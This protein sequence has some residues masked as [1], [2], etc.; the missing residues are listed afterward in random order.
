MNKKYQTRN[1]VINLFFCFTF[2][3]PSLCFSAICTESTIV[4]ALKIKNVFHFA[5]ENCENTEIKIKNTIELR[6]QKVIDGAGKMKL[7]WTGKG[8]CS[9]KENQP[10][11]IKVTGSNNVL[12]GFSMAWSPDGI[13]LLGNNNTVERVVWDKVCEDALTNRGNGNVVRRSTFNKSQDKCI[14]TTGQLRVED[15]VFKDCARSIGSCA[16]KANSGVH[17]VNKCPAASFVTV[18]R[19]KF[20][21]CRS[22]A[23]RATGKSARKTVG[24]VKASENEFFNCTSAMVSEEE[25]NVYSRDNRVSGGVAYEIKNSGDIFECD[26]ILDSGAKLFKGSKKTIRNCAW[27]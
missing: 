17:G 7:L 6:G 4:N 10:A 16:E 19:N 13:H 27:E 23:I 21:G 8:D 12:Q 18:L 24:W 11:I 9:E 22:Y 15:S 1:F 2:F 14:T 25:G 3:I 5:K 26:T 20:Y